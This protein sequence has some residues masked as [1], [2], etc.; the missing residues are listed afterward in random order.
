MEKKSKLIISLRILKITD[1]YPKVLCF[2]GN[3]LLK[4]RINQ[5]T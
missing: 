1:K 5:S 2:L 3:Q 4:N